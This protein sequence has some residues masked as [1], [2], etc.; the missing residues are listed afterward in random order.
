MSISNIL[1]N[2]EHLPSGIVVVRRQ[3]D[4]VKCSFSE[5]TKSKTV[6]GRLK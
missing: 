4:T 5:L 1:I 2:S 3:E 6:K